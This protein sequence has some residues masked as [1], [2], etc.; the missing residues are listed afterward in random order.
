MPTSDREDDVLTMPAVIAT[1]KPAATVVIVRD[2]AE[3]IETWMMRR[4]RGMAFAAGAAVF[5]GGGVD[6]R[7]ADIS[8]PWIGS[9]PDTFAVRL[10]TDADNA[11][12][13]V[14]AA[15]RELFEETGV[16][17]ADP[18]PAVDLEQARAALEARTLSLAELLAEHGCALNAGIVHPW[19]R[20]ITPRVETRRYDTWFF[21]A[22]LPRG[23][24]A[25]PVSSEAD[26]AGWIPVDEV[27]AWGREG[28]ALLLPPTQAMLNALQAAGTVAAVLT[29]APARSLT[30]V[31]PHVRWGADGTIEVEA[32]G[33]LYTVPAAPK[34]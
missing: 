29:Q 5:P 11:R 28:K 7:D 33:I 14:T 8:V 31:E 20:W 15:L 32:D 9:D 3:G 17:L 27:I 6:P 30:P 23:V 19:A 1:P 22:A 13:L 24:D 2:G 18:L 16:L 4:V 25:Q 21:V 12:E 34:S 26:Q 10:E